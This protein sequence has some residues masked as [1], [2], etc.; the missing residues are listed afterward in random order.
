VL[1]AGKDLTARLWAVSANNSPRIFAGHSLGVTSVAFSPDGKYALTGSKDTTARL[2]DLASGREIQAFIGHTNIIYSVAFSPD[3]QYVLTGSGDNTARLW[4]AETAREIYTLTGNS[5]GGVIMVAFSPDNRY[6]LTVGVGSSSSG[7]TLLW[8]VKSGQEVHDFDIG[9]PTND[10][11]FA[12]AFSSDSKYALTGP[13]LLDIDTGKEIRYFEPFAVRS[14][15]LSPDGKY[16]LT[17]DQYGTAA[18][19]WDF[20]TD[21]ELRTFTEQVGTVR[22]VA[23]SPDG[24][25]ALGGLDNHIAYLWDVAT[26]QELRQFIGHSG[27]VHSVAFSPDGNYVLTGSEDGTARL[28]DTDYHDTIQFVCSL[29]SRDLSEEEKTRFRI[30]DNEPTC[31]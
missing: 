28:W 13:A 20:A 7:Q 21:Q 17:S 24:K 27:P 18:R 26:G 11:G 10:L 30:L 12:I 8:D 22:S 2:W 3:G 5:T 1:S 9:P 29:L 31:P 19:L 4:N 23:F 16:V 25:Y 6:A 14:L 15:A